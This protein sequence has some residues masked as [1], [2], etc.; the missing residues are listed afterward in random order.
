MFDSS[1][2]GEPIEGLYERL[3]TRQLREQIEK[4]TAGGWAAQEAPLRGELAPRVLARHVADA[5]EQHLS[6][7]SPLEQVLASNLLLQR[8]SVQEPLE[9]GSTDGPRQL[10]GLFRGPDAVP[11]PRP[12]T[13]L[14]EATLITNRREA[15]R[16]AEEL[17]AEIASADRIDLLCSFIKW[18]GLNTIRSALREATHR[19]VPLRVLTT[20]YMGAT[21]PG[22]LNRLVEDFGAEVRVN[23]EKT[24]WNVH[25]KAWYFHRATGFHTAYIGSSNLSQSALSTGLEWNVRHS[26]ASAPGVLATF[27]QTFSEY[28]ESGHFEPYDP[29]TDAE[30][31]TAAVRKR[32]WIP[33]GSSRTATS[34]PMSPQPHQMDMLERLQAER[35]VHGKTDALL[36]APTGTGKTVMAALDYSWLC[37]KYGKK[38]R[39]LF[40]AH[41]KE[42]LEQARR[43]YGNVLQ[44]PNFGELHVAGNKAEKWRHVFASVQSFNNPD[45]LHSFS[46]DSFDVLVIDEF[47]H[48][49]AP[50]YRQLIEYFNA[51]DRH[52]LGM[53]A[54]PERHDGEHVHHMYFGGRIAAEMRLW[55]ALD[56]DLLSPFH[57]YGIADDTAQFANLSWRGRYDPA[58]LTAVLT[59]T[60][61]HARLVLNELH[62]KVAEPKKMRALGFC[63]SVEHAN[64]MARHF[65]DHG[66]TAKA[67]SAQTN[68]KER[69][70]ALQGL[71]EGTI[72]ALFSVNLF[73]E[74]L[75][76]PDVDTLLFLRPTESVTVYLQQFGRGLR[77]TPNKD[78]LTVLD[79]VG[80]HRPEYR[81]EDRLHAITGLRRERLVQGIEND[82]YGLPEGTEIILD[83]KSKDLII[84]NIKSRIHCGL[85]QLAKEAEIHGTS[86]LK[87]FLSLAQRDITDIYHNGNSWTGVL[88]KAKLLTSAP[89][90]GEKTLLKRMRKF[91]HTDDVERI[92]VYLRILEA[93]DPC[94]EEMTPR[95]QIYARMLILNLWDRG[96]DFDSYQEALEYLAEQTAF[97]EEA[98]QV[99]SIARERIEHPAIPLHEPHADIPLFVHST[100]TREELLTALGQRSLT[101]PPG[102]SQAG[103]E[104]CED[105][106][107]D[108][109]LVTL[110]KDEKK[111]SEGVRYK[112]YAIDKRH[113]HWESQNTASPQTPSGKRHQMHKAQGTHVFLFVRK[114]QENEIGRS[115]YTF[116]GPADYVSHTG[117]KPMQIIW[118]LKYDM[119][120]EIVGYSPVSV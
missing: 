39:L 52:L 12:S 35:E 103:V 115:P 93:D 105:A 76:I 96:G 99:L 11:R 55:E 117:E 46:R 50:T 7:L 10:L 71:S 97:R 87:S 37:K 13:P 68:P 24:A 69:E 85:I 2:S 25:A 59:E 32:K 77:R 102:F 107:T 66:I 104:W 58:E 101:R 57:Y 40:I 79:F 61:Q 22:A 112:D 28:W 108:A 42:I 84:R 29:A 64:F 17:Q 8:L 75:D 4:L 14:S 19:G 78:L 30:R 109:L 88:H 73:N 82:S 81:F 72:Q 74:G 43:T 86:A 5:V 92:D 45:F 56:S 21:E 38:L 91:V 80:Q 1:D 106:Q 60:D 100:Y 31:L 63:V 94:Y 83:R 26:P 3:I 113:F 119:P 62:D 15:V 41:T 33:A 116:L 65:C 47:H 98:R 110:V 9:E 114:E 54:T 89:S 20:T 48:S 90:E 23:Y 70:A 6:A 51:E 111:F 49:A 67:L 18:S 36:V 27:E 44:D 118:K 16:M 120:G 34:A 53:T 95:E